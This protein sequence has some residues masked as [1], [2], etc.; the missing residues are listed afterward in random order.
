MIKI[1]FAD[2]LN[3]VIPFCTIDDILKCSPR[4]YINKLFLFHVEGFLQFANSSSIFFKVQEIKLV[5]IDKC[6]GG[7]C[8]DRQNTVTHL[9]VYIEACRVVV[10]GCVTV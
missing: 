7:S 2:F 9:C 5:E 6:Q 1:V 10:I 3:F 4:M 8:A